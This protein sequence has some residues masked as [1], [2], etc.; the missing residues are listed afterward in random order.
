MISA[1]FKE[2]IMNLIRVSR[3]EPISGRVLKIAGLTLLLFAFYGLAWADIDKKKPVLIKDIHESA[4]QDKSGKFW[5]MKKDFIVCNASREEII[6]VFRRI[7]AT[8]FYGLAPAMMS[9]TPPEKQNTGDFKIFA[10]NM[11]LSIPVPG[12]SFFG[13]DA[14]GRPPT[15]S[16]PKS[17]QRAIMITTIKGL[18]AN[19]NSALYIGTAM[20]KASDGSI[21]FRVS[22]VGSY[23][24][25][26]GS[27]GPGML[28][29][30][31]T[32]KHLEIYVP[33]SAI[34]R[35]INMVRGLNGTGR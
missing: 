18:F 19:G 10:S 5:N 21:G 25:I 15:Q 11:R 32:R 3:L 14:I 28:D 16:D 17:L 13:S 23:Y 22:E 33:E 24:S 8:G 12:A 20:E 26:A 9:D 4:S 7:T 2:G 35:K 1:A 31:I 27:M 6:E 34:T 30:F 29:E